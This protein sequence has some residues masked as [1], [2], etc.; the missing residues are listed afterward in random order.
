[1][2]ASFIKGRVMKE[3]GTSPDYP[4]FKSRKALPQKEP[5]TVVRIIR[6]SG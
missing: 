1:M 2:T 4:D 5:W 6:E 3:N